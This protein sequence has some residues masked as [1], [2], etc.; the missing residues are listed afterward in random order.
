MVQEEESA[1]M[2]PL[3]E[4]SVGLSELISSTRGHRSHSPHPFS[5]I[6]ELCSTTILAAPKLTL[7]DTAT[8]PT[9]PTISTRN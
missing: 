4:E 7:A 5:H 9:P 8:S 6:Q 3:Q 2:R 1:R